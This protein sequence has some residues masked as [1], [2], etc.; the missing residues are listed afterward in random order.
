MAEYKTRP[1]TENPDPGRRKSPIQPGVPITGTTGAR[2]RPSRIAADVLLA[3][4]A[5]LLIIGAPI[6]L[7]THTLLAAVFFSGIMVIGAVAII[8][9]SALL[10]VLGAL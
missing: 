9:G 4:G 10:S 5:V 8:A 1:A 6:A 2:K 3:A 7:F